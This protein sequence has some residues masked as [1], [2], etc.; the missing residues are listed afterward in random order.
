[1]SDATTLAFLLLMMMNRGRT[2]APQTQKEPLDE[3]EGQ[4]FSQK[5]GISCSLIGLALAINHPSL[6]RSSRHL[7]R[8]TAP[9]LPRRFGAFLLFYL[10]RIVSFSNSLL[11]SFSQHNARKQ[12]KVNLLVYVSVFFRCSSPPSDLLNSPPTE[13]RIHGNKRAMET[14]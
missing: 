1:M 2:D 12:Q 6:H 11:P 13:N 14:Q 10:W 4:I 8:D 5:L 7:R 9:G 3:G